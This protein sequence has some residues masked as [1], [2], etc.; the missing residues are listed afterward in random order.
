MYTKPLLLS[1]LE[2]MSVKTHLIEHFYFAKIIRPPNSCGIIEMLIK[3]HDQCTGVLWTG[4]AK[5]Q[6]EKMWNIVPLILGGCVKLLD[7]GRKWNTLSYTSIHGI[8]NIPN[9]Y[10]FVFVVVC[11]SCKN[12]ECFQFTGIVGIVYRAL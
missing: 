4:H 5:R 1:E 9:G 10:M 11:S 7:T 8:P 2:Q 6:S 12:Q 3:H